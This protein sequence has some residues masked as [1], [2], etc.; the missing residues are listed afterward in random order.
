MDASQESGF[1]GLS[2]SALA[3]VIIMVLVAVW[4]ARTYYYG[5]L[6]VMPPS[7]KSGFR[8]SAS[9]EAKEAFVGG[10]FTYAIGGNRVN[11]I[12]TEPFG[13]VAKGAGSPDCLRSSTEGAALIALFTNLT[14]SYEEGPD[15]L[16]ELTQLVS[17]LCCFKKDLVSP[18]YIVEATRYQKYVTNHDIEPIAE[19]TGRCFAKT[20]GPRDLDLAF[21]KWTTRG[22]DLV[23]K[24]CTAYKLAPADVEQAQNLFR[25]LVRDVRDIARGACLEGEP[26]IAG[27]PGPRDA[28]P[29]DNPDSAVLGE[30]KGYY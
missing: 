19:T 7:Y 8:G 18:S 26:M 14:P 22:E 15:A 30:Y 11:P 1:L 20:M 16:T 27:K 23:K 29:Y 4:S 3:I 17:K 25:A 2:A 28:H 10:R 24:L 5:G 12:N 13:G 21:D 6:T 9:K